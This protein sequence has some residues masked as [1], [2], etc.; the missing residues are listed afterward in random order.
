MSFD[1]NFG[2]YSFKYDRS[3]KI[4]DL[5]LGKKDNAYLLS[6]TKVYSNDEYYGAISHFLFLGEKPTIAVS[7]KCKDRGFTEEIADDKEK[8]I[9]FTL[10]KT[11]L[12]NDL[13]YRYQRLD[14]YEYRVQDISL[15]NVD[16]VMFCYHN[17]EYVHTI[18]LIDNAPYRGLY[19]NTEPSLSELQNLRDNS[20]VSFSNV[21]HEVLTDYSEIEVFTNALQETKN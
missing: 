5:I 7:F 15:D 14:E 6:I 4:K 8:S 3:K 19:G 17:K 10:S 21:Y 13:V 1:P 12:F 20:L 2:T 16:K 11:H 18:F 9:E